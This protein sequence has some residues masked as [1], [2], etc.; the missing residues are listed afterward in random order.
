MFPFDIEDEEIDVE[1]EEETVRSDYEINF[2]TGELTGRIITGVDAI[3]QWVKIV[4]L[5]DR[6]RYPQYSWDHGGELSTLIGQ[7]YDE[8]Y[9]KSEVKRMIEDAILIDEDILG[10]EDLTC[11]MMDDRLSIHFYLNT[12]YGG[13]EVDV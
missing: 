12:I 9:V 1:V 3:K 7:G 4:L 13:G 2:E 6:Y 5:T 8:A 10:I 11:S